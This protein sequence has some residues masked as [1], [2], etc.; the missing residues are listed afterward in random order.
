M[1]HHLKDLLDILRNTLSGDLISCIREF[2]KLYWS[3]NDSAI[4]FD[5]D[6]G[7][8]IHDFAESLEYFEDDTD[9]STQ[10]GLYGRPELIRKIKFV[11]KK[12]Q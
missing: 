2:E 6:L 3:L 10:K 8:A 5:T 12:S 4:P 9:K 11:L 1:N 7:E